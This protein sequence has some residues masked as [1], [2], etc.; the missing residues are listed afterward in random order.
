MKNFKRHVK[1]ILERNGWH[2]SIIEDMPVQLKCTRGYKTMYIRAKH[3][4][5][6]HV[7][8]DTFNELKRLKEQTHADIAVAKVNSNNE[9]ILMRLSKLE[10]LMNRYPDR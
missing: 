10:Q 9:I 2:C 4:G 3:G 6:K 8:R 1:D 7:Y 5:H